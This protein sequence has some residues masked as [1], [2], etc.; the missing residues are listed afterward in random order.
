ML[1]SCVQPVVILR[2]VFCIIC[3]LSMSD[4]DALGDHMVEHQTDSACAWLVCHSQEGLC[5]LYP[6]YPASPEARPPLI[7][8]SQSCDPSAPCGRH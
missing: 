4:L 5:K 2:A 1:V 6:P 8:G 7:W 3:S